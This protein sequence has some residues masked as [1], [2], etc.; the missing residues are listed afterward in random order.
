VDQ[1]ALR[2]ARG[3]LRLRR[4]AAEGGH[5]GLGPHERPSVD[6]AYDSTTGHLCEAIHGPEGGELRCYSRTDGTERIALDGSWAAV[7][8]G[9]LAYNQQDD[10]FY[11]SGNGYLFTVLGTTHEE[12]GRVVHSCHLPIQDSRGLAYNPSTGMLW[13]AGTRQDYPGF[14]SPRFEE[15][16][17]MSPRTCE[18]VSTASVP[19]SIGM[20]GGLDID[21]AG[22]LW[23]AGPSTSTVNLLD[24]DDAVTTDL[25]WLTVPRG[26]TTIAAGASRT[27]TVGVHG[28]R[29]ARA[30]VLPGNVVVRTSSGRAS[31][32]L[33]PLIVTR[34]AYRVG[35][36][37]GG[38]AH[39]DPSG[40]VWS[41]DR[42]LRSGGWGFRGR[43]KVVTTPRPIAGTTEDRLYRTA[44]VGSGGAFAYTFS[45]APAGAYSVELGFAEIA[46][47]RVGRRVFDVRVDGRIVL[48]RLDVARAGPRHALLKTLR[49]E[50]RRNGP[51]TI[52]FVPRHQ[53]S[54][55]VSS[56]RVTQRPDW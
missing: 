41:R 54:P 44:R 27:F 35:V 17:E 4:H 38:R 20:A 37:V 47:A 25:P 42:E 36:D 30:G 45:A 23:M 33:V 31:T 24:V 19:D 40:L 8:P 9:G 52:R 7:S 1:R 22:R 11:L 32:H 12:P 50:H 43:T 2:P 29:A 6:L 39:R 13:E 48:R 26:T 18:V 14:L 34:S 3:P 56:I 21:P 28:A 53:S 5:R 46:G 15:L 51:L 16:Q 55:M 49:I 10:V